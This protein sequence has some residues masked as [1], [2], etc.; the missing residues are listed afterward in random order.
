MLATASGN[1]FAGARR[2]RGRLAAELQ[3]SR[4]GGGR[5]TTEHQIVDV[6]SRLRTA[7]RERADRTVARLE[8]GIRAIEE[9][10]ESVTARAIEHETALTFKTIQRNAAAY[11]IYKAAAAAFLGGPKHR[12]NRGRRGRASTPRPPIRDSLMAYKKPQLATR[13]RTALTRIEELE[14]ALAVQAAACQEQHLRTILNLR[15]DVARLEAQCAMKG[16]EPSRGDE[17]RL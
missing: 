4:H 6:H 5:M 10:H 8:V 13:L 1:G 17:Q 12:S 7:A 14:T 2:S 16:S 15:V 11:E 3:S 9:R